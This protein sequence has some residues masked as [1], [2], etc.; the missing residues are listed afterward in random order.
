LKL[1]KTEKKLLDRPQHRHN[2]HKEVRYVG[3]NLILADEWVHWQAFMNKEM[4]FPVL[5]WWDIS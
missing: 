1:E 2:N 5:E 3:E 4:I